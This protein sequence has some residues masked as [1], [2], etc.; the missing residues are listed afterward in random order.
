MKKYLF[1]FI[2]S[3]GILTSCQD[4][5]TFNSPAFQAIVNNETWKA[6][7]KNAII[8][9][10]GAITIKGTS[11]YDNLE[12]NI[13]SSNVG[14][15]K[16]GTVNQMNM[17][18]FYPINTNEDTFY[19]TGIIKG[20]VNEVKLVNGGTGYATASIVTT[21]GGSGTGLK[22]NI[23]AGSNGII[24]KVEI[25]VP[26]NDYLP[27]DVITIV[28]GNNNASF[29]VVS[30]SKSNG[31]IVITENTGTTISGT[32]KFVAFDEITKDVISCREGVFYKLPIT[33]N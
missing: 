11:Q 30:V 1:L 19:S 10:S 13:S 15:Y 16:L 21:T 5:I 25:N 9:R 26:G 4:D 3:L 31:E 6:N 12:L 33:T 22:V 20:S 28:G 29:M 8:E 32:F 18:S 24:N 2:G 27:G 17:A 23:T 14:S 7:L